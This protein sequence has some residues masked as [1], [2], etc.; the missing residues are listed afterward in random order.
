MIAISRQSLQRAKEFIL[1]FRAPQERSQPRSID[2][3]PESLD[4]PNRPAEDSG[5]DACLHE[6]FEAQV[7]AKPNA[8]ALVAG[9]GRL[10]YRELNQRANRLAHHLRSL[11]VGP[12]TLVGIFLERSA[13]MVIALLAVL[14]AGGAYV[15]LDPAYPADRLTFMLGDS[16]VHTLLTQYSFVS[17]LQGFELPAG[18]AMPHLVCVDMDRRIARA[19]VENPEPA[20]E[21][22]HL[23]YVIYTSGSTGRPKGVALEHRNVV[24]FVNWTAQV[25]S[26]RELDGV[27]AGTSI[28]FDPSILDIFM[29]LSLGGRVIMA[30]NT[31]ALPGLP[32]AREVR[33][34][35]SVPS[36]VREL[37]RI[38]GLPPSVETVNMGGEPLSAQLVEELYALPHIKRVHD[39]YGPTETTVCSTFSLRTPG[40][41]V[42]I[43]RPIANTQVYLLDENL[44]PVSAGEA[45]ELFI[46]GKGVA[47]GYLHRPEITVEKFLELPVAGGRPARFYRTGDLCRYRPD[48]NL[49]FVGRRDQQVK[50]RGHRIELG[51]I[52]SVLLAHPDVGET[53]VIVH[54][55]EPGERRLAAYVVPRSTPWQKAGE[56]P[57]AAEQR[58]VSRLRSHLQDRLPDYMMPGTFM[59]LDRFELTTN[60]KISHAALPA[61]V[62]NRAAAG[63]FVAPRTS[64][65]KLLCEIWGGLLGLNQVG[66]HDDFFQLGGDSLMGIAMFAEVEEKTG[67]KLPIEAMQQARSVSRLAAYLDKNQKSTKP[68]LGAT[69]VE[70]QPQ[71]SRPPLFLVHGVGGGMLWGYANLARHLGTDQPVYAFKACDPDQLE[72][73]D[74][75]DKIAE[76]YTREL[77]RF[78]PKGPYMLGGYCFGGNVAFEM[79]RLLDQQGER[80]SL[81]ALINSSTHNSKYNRVSWTPLHLY[82]FLRNLGHYARAFMQW[83]TSR[84]WR[85]F[86]WKFRTAKKRMARWLG[87][88]PVHP[89]EFDADARVDLSSVSD[90]QRSL[91]ESHV[92]VLNDH[93]PG[94]Y[95]GKVLLLRTRGHPLNCS[96]DRQCGWGE[97]AQGGVTVE[98][99][100]GLHDSLMEEPHVK[101]LARELKVHLDAIPP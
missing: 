11:G 88:A 84:Q 45:G 15:P 83:D 90:Q 92:R 21:A 55:E 1:P 40:G 78:R 56:T 13:D 68:V 6:L 43:G 30:P 34:I 5:R 82:K 63:A 2:R 28:S 23:A 29:P 101:M 4:E 96:Y 81:L 46:G 17:R 70:I 69:L 72:K 86:R 32:A 73:F 42:T 94:L 48:G 50:I 57:A 47:R 74:T 91:W 95:S 25:F 44:S 41:P 71:G 51:E 12:E 59:L 97:F 66:V 76:H 100:S 87:L 10:T 80:V 85:F 89:A 39:L 8:Q 99:I 16:R 3:Q 33:L 31:L 24:A 20:A 37:L 18:Q 7:E 98:V 67:L 36:V 27:L 53:A 14:K 77:R 9:A 19:S 52:E 38:G 60:G 64:T 22:T 93:R 62:Q 35:N 26:P 65:E 61:P 49:E 79:A 58:I 75:V 54:E